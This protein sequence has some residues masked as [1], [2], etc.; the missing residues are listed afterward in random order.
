MV[1]P[2]AMASPALCLTEHSS[3]LPKPPISP[4]AHSVIMLRVVGGKILG[5]PGPRK[6]S[7]PECPIQTSNSKGSLALMLPE[8]LQETEPCNFI[9]HCLGIS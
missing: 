8:I 2:C 5:N 9:F 4:P 3:G 1:L 6:C 7:P